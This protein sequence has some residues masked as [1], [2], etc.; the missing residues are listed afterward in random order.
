MSAGRRACLIAVAF[1]ALWA[2]VE[3]I[4][5]LVISQYSPFQV[6]WSRYAVHL[7]LMLLVW[8]WR[9]PTSLWA[10]RRPAYQVGRSLLMLV[11]PGSW[12]LAMAWGGTSSQVMAVFWTAPLLVLA[13][14]WGLLGE[15][16]SPVIVGC[17]GLGLV[18]AWL[19]YRPG[20][21]A[22]APLVMSVLMALSFSLY[23]VLSRPLRTETTRANLFYSALGVFLVLTPLMPRVWRPAPLHDL[24]I[25]AAIGIL[26][27][28]ALW[29]ID[30]FTAFAPVSLTA[31]L[32]YL[33]VAFMTLAALG[34]GVGR[35]ALL[36]MGL[37]AV[38]ALAAWRLPATLH[39][40]GRSA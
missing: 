15:R 35:G 13:L 40:E 1:A 39:P 17:A 5:H 26:G 31:P 3:S 29:C 16:P 37:I 18:G 9:Q 38:G 12:T 34:G 2:A 4:A 22:G 7:L 10:T 28:G 36:G 21:L 19:S 25:F 32:L 8:G 27:Y 30:R 23:V 24:A 6:V 33:Q 14:A 11:M 20:H